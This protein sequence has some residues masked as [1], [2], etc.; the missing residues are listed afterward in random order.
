MRKTTLALVVL[1]LTIPGAA[2][3]AKPAQH[4][5]SRGNAAPTVMYVLKGTL[6]GYT[7][8]STTAGGSVSIHVTHSNY[9]GRT[10]KGMDLTFAVTAKTT[11]T[12]NGAT[13]IKD[14]T[15]GVVKFRA[16]KNTTVNGLLT[17]LS[18]SSMTA[19]QAIAH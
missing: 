4:T 5:E 2:L 3:A 14:G 11:T 10:L 9:H 18:A 13:T 8:A 17:T 15:R 12:L 19:F 7:A 6:S 16:L 1:A